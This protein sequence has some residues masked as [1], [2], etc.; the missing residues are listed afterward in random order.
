MLLRW[1]IFYLCTAKTLQISSQYI[2]WWPLGILATIYALTGN[3]FLIAPRIMCHC[4]FN[5]FLRGA[6]DTRLSRCFITI[7]KVL[8]EIFF[9][10]LRGGRIVKGEV[11]GNR[12]F[13]GFLLCFGSKDFLKL[14]FPG[15]LRSLI[16]TLI[17]FLKITSLTASSTSFSSRSLSRLKKVYVIWNQQA[18]K[19]GGMVS[20]KIPT[21]WILVDLA[22]QK[23][24]IWIINF[25]TCR[26]NCC[27]FRF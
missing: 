23:Q 21:L 6:L 20:I 14:P 15:F 4:V 12:L 13:L 18:T 17:S 25:S 11:F 9:F 8:L 3:Y 2:D 16:L 26:T 19:A 5:I 22:K 10:F 24:R 7:Q 1:F 27:G